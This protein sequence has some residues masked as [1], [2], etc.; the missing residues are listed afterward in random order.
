MRRTLGLEGDMAGLSVDN[1]RPRV[2][3]SAPVEEAAPREGIVRELAPWV[4]GSYAW[5]LM[6]ALT[7]KGPLKGKIAPF[8]TIGSLTAGS[9][10]ARFAGRELLDPDDSDALITASGGIRGALTGAA[11]GATMAAAGG[12]AR[13]SSLLT[14]GTAV[15]TAVGLGLGV[16]EAAT[17]TYVL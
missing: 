12:T 9:A 11:V 8:A 1:A 2:P 14:R 13:T 16:L 7:T 5:G 3:Q 10:V 4:G 6:T 17:D 15:G